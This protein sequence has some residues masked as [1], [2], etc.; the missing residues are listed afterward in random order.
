VVDLEYQGPRPKSS[1]PR[2]RPGR[3]ITEYER[4]TALWDWLTPVLMLGVSAVVIMF[5]PLFTVGFDLRV[6]AVSGLWVL[7]I[8]IVKTI[9]AVAVGIVIALVF[10]SGMD[11]LG[12]EALRLAAIAMTAGAIMELARPCTGCFSIVVYGG[13]IVVMLM[14]MLDLEQ[15]EAIGFAFA[16]ILV[17]TVAV[18]FL[19]EFVESLF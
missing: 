19:V 13:A 14:T 6:A 8:A 11:A 2:G 15:G 17:E 5:V 3:R 10:G 16:F 9:V 4:S 12:R 18:L 7:A 1:P